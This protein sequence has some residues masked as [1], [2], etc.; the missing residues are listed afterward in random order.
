MSQKQTATNKI[1]SPRPK[2]SRAESMAI[3]RATARLAARSPRLKVECRQNKKRALELVGGSHDD[4]QGW[5]DRLQDLFGT[6]GTDFAVTQLDR[7]MITCR[8]G[9]GKIDNVKLNGLLALVEGA[10]PANEVQA[11][12]A[13]QMALTHDAA[14]M[15]LQRALRVDQIPQFESASNSAVKLL[16][17]FVMQVEALAKLQRGGEQIVKVVHVHPGAQA[18]VGNIVQQNARDGGGVTDENAN[19]PHAKANLPASGF[20]PMPEVWSED[21]ERE[22]M[23]VAVCQR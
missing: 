15:V 14:Q 3:E 23:P 13:V 7:L 9:D 10:A 22:P 16:R 5:L 2:P 12:L 21:A 1:I 20:M 19:Q 4:H 17:T 8:D 18:I 11:A 6:R